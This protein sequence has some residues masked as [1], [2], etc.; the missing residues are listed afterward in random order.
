MTT[1]SLPNDTDD[2]KQPAEENN[3]P[4][5]PQQQCPDGGAPDTSPPDPFAPE[6]LRLCQDF[7]ATIGVKKHLTTVPCRKP[8]RHEFVRVRPEAEWRLETAAFEDKINRE[9]YL[10]DRGLWS[11]LAGEVYPVCLFLAINRQGDVFLWPAKLPGSDGKSNHWNESALAAARLAETSWVRVA[12]N[13]PAGLYDTFTA[14][15]EL[16]E[17]EWP[18]LSFPEILKLS[19]RDRFIQDFDHAALR[20]LRGEV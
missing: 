16:A 17:P 7:G 14:S 11:D 9:T 20:A 6:S 8:N 5:E 2:R 3:R 4:V 15:G 19:F 18:E 10:V 12:A 13:M 1:N